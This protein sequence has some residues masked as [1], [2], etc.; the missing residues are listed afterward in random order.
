MTTEMPPPGR[1]EV[2]VAVTRVDESLEVVVLPEA[3]LEAFVLSVV[4]CSEEEDDE[5]AA[6]V[7][8]MSV[9]ISQRPGSGVIFSSVKSDQ[10]AIR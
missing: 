9:E 6:T 7:R 5:E 8:G 3:W 10:A 4:P 2:S 1:V